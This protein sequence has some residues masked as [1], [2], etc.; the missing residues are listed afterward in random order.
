[1]SRKSKTVATFAVKISIPLGGNA[2]QAQQYIRECLIERG[3]ILEADH[4]FFGIKE[5]WFTVS[6]TKKETTYGA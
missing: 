1:M 5:D 6:L 4:P 3:Q 2:L